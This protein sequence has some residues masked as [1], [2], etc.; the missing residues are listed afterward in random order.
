MAASSQDLTL[1]TKQRMQDM[2]PF[3]Y[4]LL[5]SEENPGRTIDWESE[6]AKAE[7]ETLLR[8]NQPAHLLLRALLC[9]DTAE[10]VFN[11]EAIDSLVQ[12]LEYAAQHKDQLSY[13][14]FCYLRYVTRVSESGPLLLKTLYEAKKSGENLSPLHWAIICKEDWQRL[15]DSSLQ[16]QK[17][18]WDLSTPL[19]Y[20]LILDESSVFDGLL[21]KFP[22]SLSAQD[23][24]SR[25]LLYLAASLGNLFVLNTLIACDPN[26]IRIG[27]CSS[28]L[29]RAVSNGHL[30]VVARLIETGVSV[31]DARVVDNTTAL[32]AAAEKGHHD[33]VSILL[34]AGAN[35]NALNGYDGKTALYAA[36][37][38]KHTRVLRELLAAGADTEYIYQNSQPLFFA[39]ERGYVEGV[40]CLLA[41]GARMDV[42]HFRRRARNPALN[43]CK[44]D[45]SHPPVY[46]AALNGH[47]EVVKLLLGKGAPLGYLDA[48]S[49]LITESDDNDLLQRREQCIG[50]L[51]DAGLY[52]S[53][54]ESPLSTLL[55]KRLDALKPNK[56]RTLQDIVGI[57][58]GLHHDLQMPLGFDVKLNKFI[59]SEWMSEDEWLRF[60]QDLALRQDRE[61]G[62][63]CLKR[64]IKGAI[65]A[66]DG[67]VARY[68]LHNLEKRKRERELRSMQ[69]EIS[70]IT[71]ELSEIKDS[72]HCLRADM[73][74][75]LLLLS[76]VVD[77][78]P[79][80]SAPPASNST[81]GFFGK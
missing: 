57:K 10:H 29:M 37:V 45:L 25:S 71:K 58:L 48:Y 61:H 67:D 69:R 13:D 23:S 46:Y 63:D 32:Y 18:S 19:H 14:V 41:A 39:A 76:R 26:I 38:N 5:Q 1:S 50:A 42:F 80:L 28:S 40:S 21:E 43:F 64:W 65:D 9:E 4:Y 70:T 47:L 30:H 33:I 68:I 31:D 73:A 7:S 55:S 24:Q 20:A 52:V 60:E 11:P 79:V 22:D 54:S 3:R 8:L 6:F 59:F 2:M 44:V 53:S 36:I 72:V 49:K 66:G 75:M 74:R 51:F 81:P 34:K 78:S 62:R 17:S 16:I 77:S 35:V 15:P 27:F 56:V 12:T